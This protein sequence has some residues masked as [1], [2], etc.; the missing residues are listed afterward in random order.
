MGVPRTSIKDAKIALA[1][2]MLE[3]LGLEGDGVEETDEFRVHKRLAHIESTISCIQA[4]LMEN[5]QL[6]SDRHDAVVARLE[7]L[8]E[9]VAANK[10]LLRDLGRRCAPTSRE[11]VVCAALTVVLLWLYIVYHAV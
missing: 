4:H 3:E 11:G 8:Q 6:D 9:S 10:K 5:G 1:E 7:D 2:G